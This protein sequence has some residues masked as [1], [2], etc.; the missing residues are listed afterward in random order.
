M[1]KQVSGMK[2]SRYR[3]RNILKKM[4][5]KTQMKT[6]FRFFCSQRLRAVN[7]IFII[8]FRENIDN[9]NIKQEFFMKNCFYV[10]S[11]RSFTRCL[12]LLQNIFSGFHHF[13]SVD[14][15]L[16]IESEFQGKMFCGLSIQ[17]S[18]SCRVPPLFQIEKHSSEK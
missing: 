6:N 12:F 8:T 1:R 3:Q 5:V 2:I 18:S 9:P 4:L 14:Q 10:L 13:E 17:P 16:H 7:F 11:T 15:A